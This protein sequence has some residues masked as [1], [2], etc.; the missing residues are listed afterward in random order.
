M[1]CV[2]LKICWSLPA[3][4]LVPRRRLEL[5]RPFGHRYLKPARLPIPPPGQ[6]LARCPGRRVGARCNLAPCWRQSVPRQSGTT[7]RRAVGA[8]GTLARCSGGRS[9]CGKA[10][11]PRRHEEH[12][13]GKSKRFARSAINFLLRA[14]RVFVVDL[15]FLQTAP[16][17]KPI[18][19]LASS[20]GPES[21]RDKMYHLIDNV[22]HSILIRP[23]TRGH[24][25]PPSQPIPP[26]RPT[27]R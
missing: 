21:Q 12:E 6:P 18:A 8:R 20:D 11:E 2:V 10:D 26:G 5:P 7:G 19:S 27:A 4:Q 16:P 17:A 24:H 13:A 3:S 23:S 14:L 9:V 25:A 22:V 1:N 15:A